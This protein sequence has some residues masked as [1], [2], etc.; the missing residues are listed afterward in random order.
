MQYLTR[1]YRRGWDLREI[2]GAPYDAGSLP[3]H[4]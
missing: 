1:E 3:V 2:A 4:A